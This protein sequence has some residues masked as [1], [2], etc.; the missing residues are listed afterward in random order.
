MFA[1]FVEAFRLLKGHIGLFTAII[2]TVWL[3]GNLLI[4]F[5]VYNAGGA[6]DIA[7]LKLTMWLEAIF[8]PIYIGA[9]VYS[10]FQIKSGHTVTYRVAMT[11]GIKKWGA[12]FV[13][14]FVA[15]IFLI[16]GFFALV[17]PGLVLTVRYSLLDA[18]VIIEDKGATESRARS[19]ELTTGY[20]WQ[21]FGSAIIFFTL[22]LIL[23]FTIYLPL[24]LSESLNI[25]PVEVVLDCILDV[26][27]SVIQ[28][29]I[30][31]FYWESIQTQKHTEPVS[32][33]NE[34][35]LVTQP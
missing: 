1:R 28:I 12:L 25:M 27:Y 26:A 15:G 7:S 4:N 13:A 9:L 34:L 21:I 14:R 6:S 24:G 30:F 20:R 17:I 31:L 33:G 16:L 29:V 35:P 18:A 5:V 8:G 11:V 10:L 3:P 32:G 2:L 19:T 23:S 22:F